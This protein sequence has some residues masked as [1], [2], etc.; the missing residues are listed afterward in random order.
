MIV[1]GPRKSVDDMFAAR[2]AE[3][4]AMRAENEKRQAEAKLRATALQGD[5]KADKKMIERM[6]A[7]ESQMRR[8]EAVLDSILKRLDKQ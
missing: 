5:A 6:D 2:Q 1:V 8:L 4:A 3:S 7:L